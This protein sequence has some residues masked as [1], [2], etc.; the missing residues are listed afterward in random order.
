MESLSKIKESEQQ[1]TSLRE[2][3]DSSF[4]KDRIQSSLMSYLT[5]IESKEQKKI[6]SKQKKRGKKSRMIEIK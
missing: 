6:D 5:N 4:G 1:Q 2:I 3:N